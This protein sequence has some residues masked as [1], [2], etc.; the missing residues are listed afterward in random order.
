MDSVKIALL[1]IQFMNAH[2]EVYF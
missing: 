2:V 1:I